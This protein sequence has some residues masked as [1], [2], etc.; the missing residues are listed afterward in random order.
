MQ[1]AI[2]VVVFVILGALTVVAIASIIRGLAQSLRAGTGEPFRVFLEAQPPSP[3]TRT[4]GTV[5]VGVIAILWSLIHVAVGLFW[6]LTGFVLSYHVGLS[7]AAVLVLAYI[8][9]AGVLTGAGGLLLLRTVA[10]G[11]RMASWGLFLLAVFAFMAGI[12]SL[13]LP[14]FEKA[15]EELQRAATLLAT[16]F[17]I[18]LVIDVTIGAIAQKAGKVAAST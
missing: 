16:A 13:L 14:H 18:H 1:T 3:I 15:P 11:R 9:I 5:A 2:A 7:L 6:S 12:L 8:Y 10:Y 17:A 4:G